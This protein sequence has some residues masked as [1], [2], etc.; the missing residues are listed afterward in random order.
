MSIGKPPMEQ[1]QLTSLYLYGRN[2]TSMLVVM[3]I[4]ATKMIFIRAGAISVIF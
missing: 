3:A 4:L 1:R 2:K